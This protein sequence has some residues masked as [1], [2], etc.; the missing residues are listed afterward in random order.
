MCG[1]KEGEKVFTCVVHLYAP[2]C[3][4]CAYMCL[5]MIMAFDRL[6]VDVIAIV[7]AD[8]SKLDLVS[9]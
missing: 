5:T 7:I 1:F 4:C 2:F 8:S 3:D 6:T 9:V